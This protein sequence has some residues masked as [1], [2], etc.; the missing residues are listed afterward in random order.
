[1]APAQVMAMCLS[2]GA[3]VQPMRGC[4]NAG[5]DLPRI[6]YVIYLGVAC[7]GWEPLGCKGGVNKC[8]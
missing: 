3:V 4:A 5:L 2:S 1:M 6:T 8:L 7:A